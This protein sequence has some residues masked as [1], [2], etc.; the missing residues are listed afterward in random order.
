[1]YNAMSDEQLYEA[2]A[3]ARQQNDNVATGNIECEVTRRIIEDPETKLFMVLR[4]P[5]TGGLLPKIG[6]KP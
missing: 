2:Y 5:K 6:L 3:I 4:D 1:M